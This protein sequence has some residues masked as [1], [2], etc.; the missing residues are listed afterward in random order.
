MTQQERLDYLVEAFM[1]DSGEY[2]NLQVPSDNEGKRRILRSL[3]N[4]R[5]PGSMPE[6]TLKVQDAYLKCRAE[7]KGIV[8]LRNIPSL[9]LYI[10]PLFLA[11]SQRS[12]TSRCLSC[13]MWRQWSDGRS[14]EPRARR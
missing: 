12:G 5:M 6:D 14:Q 7:E 3:M 4:I 10:C 8:T 9:L 2:K 1:A 11:A 13:T